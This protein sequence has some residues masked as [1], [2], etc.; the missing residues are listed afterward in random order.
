[1]T[2]LTSS[3]M[4]LGQPAPSG[5]AMDSA[6]LIA[7][8]ALTAFVGLGFWAL[9]ARYLPPHALGV[10]TALL[11]LVT[12]A[13]MIAANG[14]GNAF[15]ALLPAPGCDSRRRL[16]DGYRIVA[17]AAVAI[18]AIAAFAGMVTLDLNSAWAAVGV[19]A[20]TVVMAFFALKDSAMVGLGAARKLP[21]QNL[22]ASAAKI[23]ALPVLCLWAWHPAFLATLLSAAAAT[24]VIIAGP[25]ARRARQQG[26]ESASERLDGP[27]SRDVALFSLRDGLAST[28]TMGV[29]L[30]LPFVT[31]AVAGPV[32]GA[33]LALAQSVAQG[34]DF[35]AAGVGT[36]LVARLSAV[37]GSL[38]R[39]ALRTWVVTQLVVIAVATIGFVAAPLV[40]VFF[41]TDYRGSGIVTVI[42]I[43]LVAS[44]MRVAF[45]I[46]ASVLRSRR[47]TG[48]LLGVSA[49]ALV[50]ALPAIVV[51]SLHWGAVGA[52]GGLCVWSSLLGLLGAAGLIGGGRR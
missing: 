26:R 22:L 18:G 40:V 11:S 13:G 45:V 48:R 23:L 5:L 38:H 43:L 31:A 14:T 52:A 49:A 30:S 44:S 50:V 39:Q 24:T 29:A 21:L 6:A 34:L 41:G 37:T 10:D 1:M 2:F 7:T 32:Q 3:R 47:Q 25:V 16:R 20:G 42:G 27:S 17:L 33:V 12:T 36:A 8:S 51:G 4:F 9:A 15:T 35:I 28:M 19:V 46:W